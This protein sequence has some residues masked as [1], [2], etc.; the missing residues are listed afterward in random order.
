[1]TAKVKRANRGNK[2]SAAS[3]TFRP[4]PNVCQLLREM[5]IT[6]DF[7]T[8]DVESLIVAH[9]GTVTVRTLAQVARQFGVGLATA[10]AWASM[11]DE[12]MPR[13]PYS[14][15]EILSWR[16]IEDE[17]GLQIQSGW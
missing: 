17:R 9:G 2:A 12:E 15:L 8:C 6:R 4:V 7:Y 13:R 3:G 5:R 11:W 16:L 1:M 10:K 14:L